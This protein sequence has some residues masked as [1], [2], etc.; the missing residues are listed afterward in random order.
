MNK[1]LTTLRTILIVC[2]ALFVTSVVTSCGNDDEPSSKG[3]VAPPLSEIEKQ[4]VGCWPDLGDDGITFLQDGFLVSN[5]VIGH[6]VYD[7]N[8]KLLTTDIMNKKNNVL[9]WQ[10][11]LLLDGSMSGIQVWN[12]KTFTAKRSVSKGVEDILENV[13]KIWTQDKNSR[14]KEVRFHVVSS[15]S[16][17]YVSDVQYEYVAKSSIGKKWL[18]YRDITLSEPDLTTLNITSKEYGNL[19]IHNP[20]NKEKV[21]VEFADGRVFYPSS[22]DLPVNETPNFSKEELKLLGKWI[23]KEQIWDKQSPGN[24]YYDDQYG[25]SFDEDGFGKMWAGRDQLMETMHGASFGWWIRN[26]ML[27]V[28]NDF[29]Y[30][31]KLSDDELELEWRDEG[32]VI[33]C[34]FYKYDEEKGLLMDQ[35]E[36]VDLG[37]SVKWATRNLGAEDINKSVLGDYFAWGE[38]TTKTSFT[39]DNYK[40]CKQQYGRYVLTKYCSDAHN[41]YD[42]FEDHKSVLDKDDDAALAIR[43]KGWRMPSLAEFEE[44][45]ANCTWTKGTYKNTNGYMVTGKNGNSIFIP[46]A[47]YKRG[48]DTKYGGSEGHYLT[49]EI[50]EDGGYS[51]FPMLTIIEFNL[52]SKPQP[53]IAC[54]AYGYSIRPVHE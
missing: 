22:N 44:L 20:Y 45:I 16:S 37:L 30:I 5:G 6:W 13:N 49:N 53:Y 24:L 48:F 10:L 3:E 39:L 1:T 17:D 47:G 4:F 36:Y 51:D 54:Q 12:G 50:G 35:M 28:D 23:C 40:Y 32:L 2:M 46:A 21:W 26:N 14:F 25:M 27:Y 19:I 8:T 11:N 7:E 41:G 43:G 34:K 33:T 38:T 31:L 15:N 9:I 52:T 42:L 29:Y 18:G